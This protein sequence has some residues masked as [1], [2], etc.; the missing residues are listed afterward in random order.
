ME[1]KER[2]GRNEKEELKNQMLHIRMIMWKFRMTVWNEP[3]EENRL[4]VKE[5][6]EVDFAWIYKN[7]A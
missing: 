2:N 4:Q 6:V 3:E 1:S 5:Y 7:F